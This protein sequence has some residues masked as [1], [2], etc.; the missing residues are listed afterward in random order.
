[1]FRTH[2]S[3]TNF[4]FPPSFRG[5]LRPNDLLNS[6]SSLSDLKRLHA[7]LLTHGLS[8]RLD[9]ATKLIFHAYTVS[10]TMDYARKLFDVTPQRDSFLWNTLIRG[11]ASIGPCQEVP[12]LYKEMH[13]TGFSPD[14][15]TF[16]FVI[17]SCSVI[18]AI[19]E[20]K[21][22]HCNIVKNGFEFNVFTQSSLI[23]MY[24]QSGE[25]SDAELVFC[26]MGERSI[27][28]WTAMVAG[29]A[30]NC[31]FGK[32]MSVF[33][34]MIDLGIQFNEITLVSILP[35][36]NEL[37]YFSL[38]RSIHDVVIKS[39]LGSYI[40]LAN[41][42]IAMYGKCGESEAA[43]SL[44]ETMPVRSLATWNTMIAV[45]EKN[46][47]ETAAIG[48]FQRMVAENLSFDS[49]TLLSVI[50]ACTGLGNLEIGRWIHE[51]ACKRGLEIDMRVGNAL[52]D[53]YAKCGR[54]DSAQGL[55]QKLLPSKS[56]ISWSAMIG[57]YAAHGH[58]KE[59]LELFSKMKDE[60][61]T[62]NSFTFTSV[63]AAC[64]H[65][66]HLEEG[67]RYFDS[68]KKDYGINHTVEHCACMVDLLG[69]A[70]RLSDAY[71]F[72]ERMEVKPDKAVWGALLGACRMHGNV[73]M[74]EL[75][76]ENLL[77][78]DPHNVTFYVLMSNLYADA[79]KWEDA[80]RMRRRMKE[81]EMKKAP[82]FS[83]VEIDKKNSSACF[84]G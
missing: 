56:V 1:M 58:A 31:V 79:G 78:L 5:S 22:A 12:V 47:D 76:V 30:Q 37:G 8:S 40:S 44:F 62:P 10:S 57:A 29:Y 43:K 72:V 60:R 83:L 38:G 25:I 61:I 46:G 69:R 3:P 55:F 65:S 28:S 9:L 33:Q 52:L 14:C 71:E 24:F 64:S 68:M 84:A 77:Q 11:Y 73:E 19:G 4:S 7:F 39:G 63:L 67:L 26:G 66:G 20:G 81:Q 17:R 75:V 54:I 59:A 15:F 23:T 21:Q 16:P 49:V 45:Y 32:A 74:A 27:V 48:I 53:M 80:A 18:S 51:L 42:L 34:K 41:A 13:R 70:G 50:S 35:A 82:G 6:C 2:L 36:C